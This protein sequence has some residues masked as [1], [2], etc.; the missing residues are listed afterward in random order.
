MV[1]SEEPWNF[2]QV[3]PGTPAKVWRRHTDW[4]QGEALSLEG[5]SRLVVVAAHPDDETLG[6]GG[7]IASAV[8]LG[9]TVDIVCVT[10]GEHSH[11]NSPTH[12]PEELG[13]IRAEEARNAADVLGADRV[14][15]LELEDG[16]VDSAQESLTTQLVEAVGD[17]RGTVIVAPWRRDGH[18]DHEVVG[19]AAAAAA[20][21]TGADLWEYP[22]WFWHWASPDEAPWPSLHPFVLDEET[23]GVKQRAIQAHA[24]QVT[25]LSALEGDE[26]LLTEEMLAHFEDGPEHYLRTPSA[27][28]PDD[29]LD[30]LH[31]EEADPWG[32]ESRWYEQRKR[33]LVL[34]MLPRPDFDRALE[35]G[36]STGALAEALASRSKHVLAVDRSSAALAA[37]RRR[38]EDREHVAV[39]RWIRC[40]SSPACRCS[41]ARAWTRTWKSVRTRCWWAW[42]GNA[43]RTSPP[44]CGCRRCGGTRTSGPRCSTAWPACTSAA[45]TSTGT[46]STPRIGALASP[47]PPTLSAAAS[48]G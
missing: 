8:R 29:S 20:R 13:R 7:L 43:W 10:D 5:I 45:W 35:I 12:T 21:R 25:P 1:G 28:C 27:E 22:V 39:A 3:G 23:L 2:T 44:R 36:C 17:G 30:R 16:A 15:R 47:C 11:P 19:H 24:S 34:A 37:A 31:E 46:A 6:A 4:G 41:N 40:A 42:A 32:A 48:T 18:P 14:L 38:F 26:T 9:R 33:D